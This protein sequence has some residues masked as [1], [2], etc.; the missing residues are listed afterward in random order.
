M[1]QKIDIYDFTKQFERYGRKNQFSHEGLE[2]LFEHL[3]Q[4]ED[5]TGENI[6]LD[7]VALCIDYTEYNSIDDILQDYGYDTI[8]EVYDRTIIIECE[9][10]YIVQNF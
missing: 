6:E 8:E 9:N 7:V 1:I 3:E 5:V 2:A 10:S 4:I